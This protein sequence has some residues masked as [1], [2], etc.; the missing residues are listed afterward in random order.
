MNAVI[1]PGIWSMSIS[2]TRSKVYSIE[3]LSGHCG[4]SVGQGVLYVTARKQEPLGSQT[5]V[6]F[7]SQSGILREWHEVNLRPLAGATAVAVPAGV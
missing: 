6:V 4:S 5:R 2:S 1:K 7:S 3:G